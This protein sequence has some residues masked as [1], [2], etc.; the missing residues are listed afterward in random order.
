MTIWDIRGIVK[1][2]E[3]GQN[4]YKI[5]PL[6]EYATYSDLQKFEKLELPPAKRKSNKT[7]G[8]LRPNYQH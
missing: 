6:D 8:R 7:S 2:G 3:R 5:C 4:S 1:N